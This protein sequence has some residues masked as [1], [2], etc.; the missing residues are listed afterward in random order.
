MT[1]PRRRYR[2]RRHRP[3]SHL[4]QILRRRPWLVHPR[5]RYR[6][7]RKNGIF[8]TRLSRTFGYT[9]KKT[10]VRT[11]SWAVDMMRFNINDFLP[12]GGG[13]NPRSVPFEYYRIRKVKGCIL[14]LLPDHPGWQ[15]S[16]LQCCILDDNFVT[17]ATALTYDPY[18]NYSSRHTITQPFSYHSRYFTPKP[19]L[20]ST[21]DY[22]QPNNKRNQLWLRLQTT[23]NVDHVGLGTAFENSIYDQEYNIRVTMYVQFRE[24]NLK[25][26]PLNP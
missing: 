19:V 22:F 23:G 2:R 5:H 12:P 25:D 6:W 8:N 14:A 10:T 9:I 20:D 21:I 13:S 11:P 3:R 18:V 26:P 1:Y 4:G 16:G 7:R 17:K 15:G 24:F